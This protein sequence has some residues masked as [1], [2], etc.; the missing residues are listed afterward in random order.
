MNKKSDNKKNRSELVFQIFLVV[1][2]EPETVQ[3]LTDMLESKDY[4]VLQAYGGQEGIDLAVEKHPDAIILDLMMPEVNGFEVVQQL[5]A[6]PEA[7]EIPIM[8]YTGKDL[9]PADRQQ[10]NSHVQAVNSKSSGKEQLL[11][12]L[13]KLRLVRL[14]R[15]PG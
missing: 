3:V 1:V 7:R 13:E 4:K 9:T 15:N 6:H 5:R 2:Y 11:G 8:I 10:L 14:V 12:E